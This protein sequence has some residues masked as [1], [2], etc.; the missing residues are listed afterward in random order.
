MRIKLICHCL[1]ALISLLYLSAGAQLSGKSILFNKG[2][3]FHKGDISNGPDATLKTDDWRQVDLPHDWS[4]EGPF[5]E[6]WAS[7]TGYLPGGIGWYQKSFSVPAEWKSKKVYIYFDGVYKNS[8]VWINGH[9][10]GNRP[11]GFIPFQYELSKFLKWNGQNI[12]SVKVD[13][14]QFA[15]S[16]WYTGSGIYR[17]VYL[18]VKDP[19]HIAQWGVQF[20]TP[21][22]SK[23]LA[24]AN[25]RVYMVNNTSQKTTA[26]VEGLLTSPDGVI[27]AKAT[28]QL[29]LA[30]ADST[31]TDLKFQ[32]KN[33]QLWSV[34]APK[35]YKLSV[36]LKSNGKVTDEWNDLVGIRNIRFDANEGFFL[37]GQNLKIKGVCIHDDA[38]A[39]GVAV[40]EEVWLRRLQLLKEAG[41][42]SI[43]MSH[44]P[45]ADYLYKLCDRLGFLVMDEAFDEWEMG[46]NKWIKGWNVGTPGKDGYSQ[47]FTQWSATDLR[48]MILRSFNRPSVFMWSIGN[49]VDYPNDPYSHEVLNTGRNPQIYGRGYLKDHPPASRLGELS[50]QLVEVAKKYDTTRPITA[51]LAGVVMSNTTTYPDN[52]DIVGYNYQEHRYDEDH[53]AYPNRFIYGS[54]NGMQLSAW[55]AVDSNQYISAQYLWTGIDYL[56]E[57]GRWPERSN[58]AGLLDL[59]GFRKPE[60][61]FRQSLWSEKPMIY[62]GTAPVPKS[63]DRGVWSHKRAEPH[64]N[65]KQGDTVRVN[66]FTNCSEAELFL[67]GR[68]LGRKTI[69]SFNNRIIHWDIV[70]QP[71]MLTV[72]GYNEQH[73]KAA[74]TT[75]T[76][77][78]K[79]SGAAYA[80][81]A[82]EE[83]TAWD[84]KT[85]LSHLV[86]Q[87]VDENGI[88]VYDAEN[89]ISV[90]SEGAELLGLESGSSNS[91]EDYKSGRRKAFHGK[92]LAYLDK[93]QQVKSVKLTLSSPGLKTTSIVLK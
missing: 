39:L 93:S 20:T 5:S 30:T 81:K 84:G 41:C 51:A 68:S 8:S 31:Y 79:T 56:G 88:P 44:N 63:E 11:N 48:D 26:T 21:K 59:A 12:I 78:L 71:G 87:I 37:N 27:V 13:H 34:D 55:N 67:N 42:N 22:V 49:E 73:S 69:S 28:G 16:R 36:K 15:D 77:T 43:R 83:K 45:H 40:P 23:D 58:R 9:Y 74:M 25:T 54:E 50:K 7:A 76:D 18:V 85:T 19:V 14:S 90:Q 82:W 64:W 65:W 10:L 47:Y 57:A 60:Y 62:I 17:D 32:V 38:G 1:F 89:E 4:I 86:M 80:I 3:K 92:L 24:E 66:C 35:L 61:Y 70:Y 33:P 75:V 46:K 2:W 52:L 72:K 53:K 6:E 91:H 29:T